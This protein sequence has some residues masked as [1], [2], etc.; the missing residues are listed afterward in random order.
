MKG[1][2]VHPHLMVSELIAAENYWISIAQRDHFLD[3][4][5]L[6]KTG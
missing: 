3:E 1:A 5:E 6:L 2:N 4:I